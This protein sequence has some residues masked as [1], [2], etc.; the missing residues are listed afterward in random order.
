MRLLPIAGICLFLSLPAGALEYSIGEAEEA[1][2]N[3]QFEKVLNDLKP[4][5]FDRAD[6]KQYALFLLGTAAF[7]QEDYT[8]ALACFGNLTSEYPGSR[9]F[10]KATY[11]KAECLMNLK[12]Y[13]EAEIIYAKGIEGLISD[14]RRSEIAGIYVQHADRFFAPDKKGEQP[15]YERALKLYEFARDILP[16]GQVWER[17]CY[18]IA[19]T[20]FKQ[21]QWDEAQKQF[22]Q[23]AVYYESA[24]KP[25]DAAIEES[26]RTVPN[27]YP[28]GGYLD[29]A[30]LHRGEAFFRLG[31]KVEARRI[32]KKL[33]APGRKASGD[34][35]IIADAAFRIAKTYKMPNPSNDRNLA[36][37]VRYLEAYIARFPD[38]ENVPLAALN[39]SK[40]YF[41]RR[42]YGK[43]LDAFQSVLDRYEK[44]CD[45]RQRASA[46]FYIA[47]SLLELDRFDEAIKAYED[48]LTHHPMDENWREAQQSIV[49]SRYRKVDSLQKQADKELARWKRN[50]R[51]DDKEPDKESI[52]G[53]LLA[54]Y[55]GVRES[56]E[57][58]QDTYPLDSQISPI[59]LLLGKN[60]RKLRRF[61][62]A[63]GIW[64][65]LASRFPKSNPAS[66]ALYRIAETTEQDLDDYDKA[67][68]LYGEV[69][70]GA[71]EGLAKERIQSLKEI[72][73]ALNTKR[74]FRTD[75]KPTVHVNSRNIEHL[76]CKLYPLD[77]KTYFQ[78]K[79]TILNIENLDI[80]LIAPETIW[81]VT[82]DEYRPYEVSER[83]ISVPVKKA[84][85]WVVKVESEELEA[86][87]LLMVSDL[88]VAIKGGKNE[89]FVYAEDQRHEK[90]LQDTDVFVSDGQSIIAQGKTNRDGV[91]HT[92][93]LKAQNSRQLSVFASYQGNWAGDFLNIRKLNSA[94]SL[95]PRVFVYTDQP[96]YRPGNTINFRAMIREIEDG[97]YTVP[98]FEYEV[99]AL[100]TR[101]AVIY[102]T[103]SALSEFGTLNGQ[104]TL[105]ESSPYGQYRIVIS[106][107]D[108]PSGSW[109]FAV[110]EFTLPSARVEVE[111]EQ[112]TYFYGD[113][114]TGTIAVN[115]FSGN[116]LK[117]ERI[118][119]S[120]EGHSEILDGVTNDEGKIEFRFETWDMP[121]VGAFQVVGIL[122]GRQL[123]GAKAVMLVNT[124][125]TIALD[126]TRTTYLTGEPFHVNVT[127]RSRDEK[128]KRLEKSLTIIL[129]K[130][131]DEGIYTNVEEKTVTTSD[132][133]LKTTSVSFTAKSGG[134]YQVVA[135]GTDRR[136]TQVTSRRRIDISGEDDT[137]KLLILSDRS[138]Y[139][140]GETATFTVVSR[141]PD[142]LCLMTGER[143]GVVE[144]R[145]E[146]L[147]QGKNTVSWTLDDR[148]SPTATVSLTVMHD[149]Q[150]HHR[151]TH[152]QVHR[153]LDLAITPNRETY[154]PGDET[155]LLVEAKDHTGKPVVAE[156]SLGLIDAALLSIFPDRAGDPA[157]FFDQAARGRFI[158]TNSSADF[159]YNG[160]TRAISKDYLQELAEEQEM[161]LGDIKTGEGLRAG[162]ELRSRAEKSRKALKDAESL[163][164]RRVASARAPAAPQEETLAEHFYSDKLDLADRRAGQ[165]LGY[166]G[167]AG[168]ANGELG[169]VAAD[170]DGAGIMDD[171]AALG[172][173]LE[174]VALKSINGSATHAGIPLAELSQRGTIAAGAEVAAGGL[175][176]G[177]RGFGTISARFS[178]FVP[179][180]GASVVTRTYFPE[181]AYFN[182]A[183]ITDDK[184]LASIKVK[185]PDSLTTWEA[186]AK[187]ITKDTLVNHAKKRI[188]VDKP[189]RVEIEAPAFLTEGDESSGLAVVRNN[190]D[191]E[192]SAKTTFVQ[193]VNGRKKQ[194]E[195]T[196][197]LKTGE[198]F[199]QTFPLSTGTP[200]SSSLTLKSE[201]DGAGDA[202]LKTLNVVP[203]GIPIRAGKSAVTDQSIVA[204][205]ME[206]VKLQ[207]TCCINII[208]RQRLALRSIK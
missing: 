136:G 76:T 124:G 143:E 129:Q 149:N 183:V 48:F 166:G 97:R 184:G 160:T 60:E 2:R 185:L 145:I 31:N 155:E 195:W 204:Q 172:K 85:A 137:N 123:Q 120:I 118:K 68:D 49:L 117:G 61:E 78:S 92:R 40:G 208:G 12:R 192:T 79:H 191:N 101:G 21:E 10:V 153:G 37:G 47:R 174:P 26:T 151:E 163:S 91:F 15:N 130:R 170:A 176:A 139:Q 58:F 181:T 4:G 66:E 14:E 28:K 199:K 44:R 16:K 8:Q 140:Q 42:Q 203:W 200:G 43:A 100:D 88:A 168:N 206:T 173:Q 59:Q 154:L 56:W 141:M 180:G 41:Q 29:C 164:R 96:V 33:R 187:A 1:L 127:A 177:Y 157:R 5:E 148:Y 169:L 135:E 194:T 107:K 82:Q 35:S 202:A 178:N 205:P 86:L 115:D 109:V 57:T 32:W 39:I 52:P 99:T 83:D 62:D 171:Y 6:D 193:T 74:A 102:R 121:E 73:L 207:A 146:K 175:Y 128:A 110:Q 165:T 24:S 189:F 50:L 69:T 9:W 80:N 71:Y 55:A 159:A 186:Q 38:H 114:I 162:R 106:R 19:M 188:I 20:R 196:A 116:P 18:Q 150:F 53:E 25:T 134:R 46:E 158:A 119:Y 190:T 34:S 11:K 112:A 108:G 67:I 51:L 64:K 113:E 22:N 167:M 63:I 131:N 197:E 30:M 45:P 156:L 27:P 84:G 72:F 36:L 94:T 81:H 142:N 7:H 89:I 65:D 87:T 17:V 77:L 138:R 126:T 144:Y 125:F 198:T 103:K 179:G 98:G 133:E 13:D 3:L 104:F 105:A 75:E 147:K 182:A 54:R 132:D 95:Q 161:L 111:T 70:F 93:D 201:A 90:A 122:P 152:F 23:L